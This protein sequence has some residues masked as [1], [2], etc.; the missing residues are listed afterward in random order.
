MLDSDLAE[1]YGVETR[2][3]NQAIKR[4]IVRFPDSFMFQ[5]LE[6]EWN[7]LISQFV[8]SNGR[9]GRRKLPYAF[10]EHG[11]LMLSSVLNSTQAI[12][13]SIRII[14][15]FVLLREMVLLHKDVSVLVEQVENRL[16]KQDQKIEVLF[17]Y[18]NKFMDKVDGSKGKIGFKVGHKEV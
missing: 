1:L 16:M 13:M 5:L 8:I 17:T 6:E 9:G 11:I 2:V 15:M 12:Q 7:A 18:L 4:N 14:E 10:T 3:L